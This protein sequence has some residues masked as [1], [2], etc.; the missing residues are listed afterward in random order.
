MLLYV[1]LLKALYGCLCSVLLLYKE[2]LTD[3]KSIFFDINPY[4]LCVINKTING[5][6]FTITWHVDN[7]KL[8]HINNKM[9]DELID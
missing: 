2:L 4:N 9:V 3:I 5:N 7:L 6:Q 8:S 1:L